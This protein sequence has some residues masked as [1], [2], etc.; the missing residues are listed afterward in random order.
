MKDKKKEYEK[1]TAVRK[2]RTSNLR[3]SEGGQEAQ[4]PQRN[5]ASA[6]QVYLGSRLGNWSCNAGH[7]IPQNRKGCIIFW[8]SNSLIQEVLAENGFWHEYAL[9]VIQSFCNQLS[10]NNWLHRYRHRPYIIACHISEVFEDVATKITENSRRRQPPMLFD[11]PAQRNPAN[12]CRSL[13]FPETSHWPT[14]LSLVVWVYLHSNLCSVLWKTH[15]FCN[16][17]RF[18]RSISFNVINV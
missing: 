16:K 12:I 10:A 4:L 14:F 3:V 5:S 13:I 17:V 2:C 9:K 11:A 15:L 6:A 1:W 18:G 7:R 8:H